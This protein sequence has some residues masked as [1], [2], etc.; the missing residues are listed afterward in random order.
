VLGSGVPARAAVTLQATSTQVSSPG[1]TG[2]VCVMLSSDEPVAGIQA[3]IRWDGTCATLT[4]KDRCVA[5]GSHGKEVHSETDHQPDFTVKVLVLSLSDVDEI[6]DGPVFCCDFLGEA[7]AGSCCSLSLTNVAASDPDGKARAVNAGGPAQ[8]CTSRSGSQPGRGFG[9]P[10]GQGPLSASN[11]PP[12]GEAG[13]AAP[14]APAAAAPAGG[15]APVAQVLPGGGGRVENPPA[16]AAVPPT[17]P[18]IQLPTTAAAS[19]ATAP[20]AVLTPQAPR[21]PLP[22]P[23][24]AATSAPTAA[25]TRR[26]TP[27]TPR[28]RRPRRLSHR[29]SRPPPRHRRPHRRR[30][31]RRRTA[32]GSGA[33][34]RRA[35]VPDR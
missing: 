24:A 7:E 8:I 6:P 12:P 23:T 29:P 31:R 27:P 17:A 2:R 4:S 25:A 11:A 33:R 19:A 32:A 14:P 5:A 3:D 15:G 30:R 34:S 1:G 28:Q 26:V 20:A 21:P 16:A 13:S 10:S 35:R 22:P 9:S 18:A